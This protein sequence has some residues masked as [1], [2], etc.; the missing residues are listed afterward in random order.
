MINVLHRFPEAGIESGQ[1]EYLLIGIPP[2]EFG[3]F[4]HWINSTIGPGIPAFMRFSRIGAGRLFQ[5]NLTTALSDYV[6]A[7]TEA[8][9]NNGTYKPGLYAGPCTIQNLQSALG[10]T[11][12]D[13]YWMADW[14]SRNCT[15]NSSLCTNDYTNSTSCTDITFPSSAPVTVWQYS[16]CTTSGCEGCKVTYG[17]TELYIDY[18][19]AV[20]TGSG[21]T[22]PS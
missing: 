13:Y 9:R 10:A 14:D 18:D 5:Q 17:S 11:F 22:A 7:W 4:R 12:T 16:G 8:I 3:W 20:D 6:S 2:L 15:Y 1:R 19:N 21:G